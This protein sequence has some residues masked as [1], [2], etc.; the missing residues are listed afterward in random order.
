VPVAPVRR[1]CMPL[2]Q[3][4]EDSWQHVHGCA[5]RS[6][7]GLKIRNKRRVQKKSA[8]KS[9]TLH[10]GACSCCCQAGRLVDSKR[11]SVHTCTTVSAAYTPQGVSS[12]CGQAGRL[13]E[14]AGRACTSSDA[15]GR[16]PAAQCV[17]A[18]P[19]CGGAAGVAAGGCSM[20]HGAATVHGVCVHLG[21]WRD[22]SRGACHSAGTGWVCAACPRHA[23][24]HH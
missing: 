10:R 4:A 18:P 14:H 21:R 16:C 9:S 7:A 8:R 22:C 2:D 17:A 3:R 20:R 12:Y 15:G 11:P 24:G 19:A 23:D 1:P 6:I 5:P 13:V